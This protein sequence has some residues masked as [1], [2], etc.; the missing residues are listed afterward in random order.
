VSTNCS[1]DN[2]KSWRA[3]WVWLLSSD[4]DAP[5]VIFMTTL[6]YIVLCLIW[7]STWMAIKLG[8]SDAPPLW[9]AAIRFLL[10]IGILLTIVRIRGLK[11][12]STPRAFLA[13]AVPGVLMYGGSYAMVYMAEQY[14]S[15]SLTAVLFASFPIFVALLSHFLLPGDKLRRF[16]WAGMALGLGGVVVISWHSL[17]ISG[18]LFRGSLLAVFASL[19]SA[20]G[21]VFH[22]RRFHKTDIVVAATT[23]MILGGACLLAGALVS[24]S[25]GELVWS[26]ISIGSIL[27]LA[28]FGTVVAFLGY[29]WLMTHMSV[30]TVSMIAFVTPLVASFIG[31]TFDNDSFT[32]PLVIGAAMILSAVIIVTYARQPQN[33]PAVVP[34]ID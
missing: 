6:V 30:V 21:I 22:K 19:A 27:Y 16:A 14:I 9:S 33:T 12:P 5:K 18:D 28:V 3:L 17:E 4:A 32:V 1:D 34:P 2:E 13:H 8:L 24:E 31:I 25:F 15:S 11:L 7:G 23:Q 20:T 10:A 29:Y 26:P